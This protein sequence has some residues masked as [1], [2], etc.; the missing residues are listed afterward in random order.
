MVPAQQEISVVENCP[1]KTSTADLRIKEPSASFHALSLQHQLFDTQPQANPR[2]KTRINFSSGFCLLNSG[3]RCW[4]QPFSHLYLLL[5]PGYCSASLRVGLPSAV[6][7]GD[8]WYSKIF[9]PFQ[10]DTWLRKKKVLLFLICSKYFVLGA[11][12]HCT[13]QLKSSGL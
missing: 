12:C 13:L 3:R 4:G 1:S 5:S 2:W 6:L 11:E 9:F 7:Y 8:G 10:Q